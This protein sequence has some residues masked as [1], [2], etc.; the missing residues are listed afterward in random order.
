MLISS[1]KSFI[2]YSFDSMLKLNLLIFQDSDGCSCQSTG[3]EESCS[4]TDD[5]PSDTTTSSTRSSLQ[6]PG[7]R[8]AP[9]T[10]LSG[11]NFYSSHHPP[12]RGTHGHRHHSQERTCKVNGTNGHHHRSCSTGSSNNS[13]RMDSGYNGGTGSIHD[14]AT[15]NESLNGSQEPFFL[16]EPNMTSDDRVKKLFDNK[17]K[18]NQSKEEAFNN[19]SVNNNNNNNTNGSQIGKI[20]LKTE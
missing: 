15:K 6:G 20:Y 3:S 13:K 18:K 17:S 16:H 11:W 8:G 14:G 4:L 2:I 5:Y 9:H 10:V 7:G 12:A 19:E 1:N